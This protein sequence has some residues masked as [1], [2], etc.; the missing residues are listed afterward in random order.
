MD[1]EGEILVGCWD[2]T[3]CGKKGVSGDA[4]RCDSCGAGRPDDV[5]FYLPSNAKVVKDAVGIAAAKAGADWMCEYCR[6]WVTAVEKECQNCAGGQI[7]GSQR[8]VTGEVVTSVRATDHEIAEALDKEIARQTAEIRSASRQR[9]V[10]SPQEPAVVEP[11]G[12][13]R[14]APMLPVLLALLGLIG[15]TGL[16]WLIFRAK[17][18]VVAVSGHSWSRVQHVEEY[19]ALQQ[20]GWDRPADAYNVRTERRVH[21]HDRVLDHYEARSRIV[22]DR[23]ADGTE[24]VRTGTRTRSLGNGRFEREPVYTTR[25]KYRTVARTERYQEPIYRRDPVYRDYYLYTVDRWVPGED[26]REQGSGLEARWPPTTVRD[27]RQRMGGR[28]ETYTIILTERSPEPGEQARTWTRSLDEASWRSWRDG[29]I[30][31]ATI[32]LGSVVDMRAVE[33]GR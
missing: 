26:R 25:T 30:V 10:A 8:Q 17:D 4:Y 18:V 20:D 16:G 14:G 19:R 15:T 7:A 21:H 2:C 23:V 11:P 29:M 27:T 28:E 1:E 13:R 24:R 33:A 12:R 3:S 9:T 22:H 31:V 5:E 6:Q 32:R